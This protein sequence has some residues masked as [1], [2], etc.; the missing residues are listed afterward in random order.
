MAPR[1]AII[2]G[3]SIEGAVSVQLVMAEFMKGE[4]VTLMQLEV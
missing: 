1:D 4:S 3:F 2:I